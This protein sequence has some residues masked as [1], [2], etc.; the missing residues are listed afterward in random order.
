MSNKYAIGIDIGGSHISCAAFDLI[1]K[2]IQEH[3]FAESKLDKHA[4]A[5]IIFSIWSKTIQQAIEEVGKK[6]VAGLG[7]A[8]PGPFD[9]ENGIPLFTGENNKYEK[10]YGINVCEALRTLLLLQDDIP[11]RFMNDATAFAVGEE[12]VGKTKGTKKSIAVTLG[13]GLGS[14]LIENSLPVT[15]GDSVPRNGCL[16][17]LPFDNGIADDY[18]STRGLVNRYNRKTGKSVSGVKDIA[19]AAQNDEMAKKVFQEFGNDF[20]EFLKP[21]LEKF[22]VEKIVLGGNISLAADLFLPSMKTALANRGLSTVS[23]EVSELGETASIIGGARLIEPGYWQE[24]KDII[25]EM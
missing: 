22:G 20:F 9:Y 3:S 14:A 24:I 17:N 2:R 19:F 16:W 25:K 7:F 15:S 13:T 8:M 23:I 18:F 6:N 5:N 21:C 10:L 11:I 4:E 12:W 1:E